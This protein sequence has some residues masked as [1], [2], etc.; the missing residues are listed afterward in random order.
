MNTP[1]SFVSFDAT[2]DGMAGRMQLLP[3]V[4]HALHAETVSQRAHSPMNTVLGIQ[5]GRHTPAHTI[6]HM[7]C[8]SRAG[9]NSI[10]RRH[11][12]HT[13]THTHTL[14]HT[15]KSVTL[16]PDSEPT[17]LIGTIRLRGSRHLT[18]ALALAL[19]LDD[20]DTDDR[21]SDETAADALTHQTRST[22]L[23]TSR[24]P[25]TVLQ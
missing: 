3:H 6:H 20:D 12:T 8:K 11:N 9:E 25:L 15:H 17:Q 7:P 19:A 16:Q 10:A 2:P 13:D 18:L 14:A 23:L 22:V 21:R 1:W 5:R 4:R 24:T